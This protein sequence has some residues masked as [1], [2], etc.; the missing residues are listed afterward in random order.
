MVETG[1]RLPDRVT[2]AA[3]YRATGGSNWTFQGRW[4]STTP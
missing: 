4:L 2:L 1:V 3:L